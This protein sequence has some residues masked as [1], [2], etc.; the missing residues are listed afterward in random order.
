MKL[1]TQLREM[2]RTQGK[3]RKTADAY[4]GWVKDFLLFARNKRGE[5]VHPSELRERHVE[6]WLKDL[7]NARNVSGN[8][9]N[10]AFSAICYLY[11]HVLKQP[12]EGV[13]ALRA[14]R[15]DRVRDVLDQSELLELF[16]QLS[17]V[18]LLV[19]R[20]MYACSFRKVGLA[21]EG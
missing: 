17:G 6:V 4:W 12:L 2:I 15:P 16:S 20:M 7:A 13:S 9:Q 19:A 10:Q 8:T 18:S 11:R 21:G 1:E 3:S 14:K 5:W